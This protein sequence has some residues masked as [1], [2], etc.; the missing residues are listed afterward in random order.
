M[1]FQAADNIEAAMI[2]GDS[3]ALASLVSGGMTALVPVG[4]ASL[5]DAPDAFVAASTEI[6]VYSAGVL[7][8]AFRTSDTP[9]LKELVRRLAGLNDSNS[10][11]EILAMAAHSLRD[12]CQED[13]ACLRGRESVGAYRFGDLAVVGPRAEC[14]IKGDCSPAERLS[15]LLV[16]SKAVPGGI[17]HLARKRI[18][19]QVR[20]HPDVI[21]T[22]HIEGLLK[23]AM[24]GVTGYPPPIL[25]ALNSWVE[26]N[27]ERVITQFFRKEHVPL[28]LQFAG[29]PYTYSYSILHEFLQGRPE[30]LRLFSSDDLYALFDFMWMP[31]YFEGV[32]ALVRHYPEIFTA[33][34]VAYLQTLAPFMQNNYHRD[35]Y[36]EV[37]DALREKRPDLF[38]K[39]SW[40]E[41]RKA[42]KAAPKTRG[43][44][45]VAATEIRRRA[46][47]QRDPVV[48]GVLIGGGGIDVAN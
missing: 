30:I 32:V 43:A 46:T 40:I 17:S 5:D 27:P 15:Q 41:K 45:L 23:L 6:P 42:A 37:L 47:A 13:V 14:L 39:L 48:H 36:Q 11:S 35:F 29:R 1:P 21:G 16:L 33:D 2:T 10:T 4:D 24:E 38:P 8:D 20:V 31:N 25:I 3:L 26:A 12:L 34:H 28:V 22:E 18:L 44:A 7:V 9:A 19:H